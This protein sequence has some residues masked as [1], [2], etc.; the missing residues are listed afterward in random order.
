MV[1]ENERIE[2]RLVS[3]VERLGRRGSGWRWWRLWRR[4]RLGI[5]GEFLLCTA[6]RELSVIP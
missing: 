6:A 2:V 4:W 5:G 1:K 3:Q